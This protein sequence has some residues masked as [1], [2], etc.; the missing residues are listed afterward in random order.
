[1]DVLVARD[2][3]LIYLRGK[4]GEQAPSNDLTWTASRASQQGL[5]G[6]STFLFDA[7]DWTMTIEYPIVAPDATIYTIDLYNPVTEF[8]WMGQVD[9]QGNVSELGESEGE[10][11]VIGWA[12][13]F[14]RLA[15]G[16]G[17]NDYFVLLPEGIGAVG[18]EGIDG[19]IE[20][21]IELISNSEEI[22]NIWGVLTCGVD[23]FNNC[24]IVVDRIR[25]GTIITDPEQ[26]EGWEGVIYNGPPGPRS[27]GDDYFAL[28]GEYPVQYGIWTK[29]ETLKAELEALRDTQ[30]VIRIW[31]M[32]VTGIPDWNATQIMVERYELVEAPSGTIP[33]APTWSEPDTGW[34]TYTNQRYGYR[35]QY[36]PQAEIEEIG[37][38]GYVTDENGMPIGGLPDGVTLDNYFAYLEET[39][40]NNLC[41][42]IRYSLGYVYISVP[43]NIEFGYAICGRTGVG[44]AEIVQQEEELVIEGMTVTATGMEVIGEG[45]ALNA[46]NETMVVRLPDGTRIEYGASPRADATYEDYLMKTKDVLVQIVQSFEYLT[47]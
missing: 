1:V 42:G 28:V 25:L 10:I 32:L 30:T 15:E 6:A 39:Y 47:E 3:A 11:P 9:A 22:V 44:V 16:A 38:Q 18:V 12:G 17:P 2:T 4:F 45:E 7:P 24:R 20:A 19:D 37:V 29:D 8:R 31:G 36:P 33:P 21:D 41:V 34:E 35:I 5:V 27:G 14:E 40:G 23:D 46:H 26:I 13:R 43:E